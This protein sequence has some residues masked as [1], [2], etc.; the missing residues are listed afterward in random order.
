[1][2]SKGNNVYVP[3]LIYVLYIINIKLPGEM[4]KLARLKARATKNK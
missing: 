2:T 4:L 3:T 1:M